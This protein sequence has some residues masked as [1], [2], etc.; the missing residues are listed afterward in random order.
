MTLNQWLSTKP[1]L[2]T[3]AEEVQ[4]G[5]I[6][7]WQD[8]EDNPMS[9]NFKT[10]NGV[11]V[12]AQTVRVESDNRVRDSRSAAGVTPLRIVVIFG[13][14][15]HPSLPDTDIKEG[16]YFGLSDNPSDRYTVKDVYF[17]IGEVQAIAEA[18]R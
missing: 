11:A 18:S 8:I 12:G 10:A 13:I 14:Y 16:Y 17:N 2:P 9:I 7:A 1:F 6:S 5:A 3:P 15:G 4:F